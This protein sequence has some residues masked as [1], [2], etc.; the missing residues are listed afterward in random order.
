MQRM[1]KLEKQVEAL[2]SRLGTCPIEDFKEVQAE[3]FRVQKLA[4]EHRV[5]LTLRRQRSGKSSRLSGSR[6]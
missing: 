6:N 1:T 3:F 4:A 2:R 5:Q